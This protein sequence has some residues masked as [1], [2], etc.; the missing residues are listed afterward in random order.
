ML[1]TK[2]YYGKQTVDDEM[3]RECGIYEGEEKWVQ[4]FGGETRIKETT[5]KIYM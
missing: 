4:S 3:S 2:H 1:L 5:R